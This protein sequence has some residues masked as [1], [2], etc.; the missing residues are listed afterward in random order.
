MNIFILPEDV[1][2]SIILF[3]L[4][5][6]DLLSFGSCSREA[7]S[8]AYRIELW[9]R[10]G[11]LDYLPQRAIDNVLRRLPPRSLRVLDVFRSHGV[12]TKWHVKGSY[13]LQSIASHC[14]G[15]HELYISDLLLGRENFGRALEIFLG[16]CLDLR[17]LSVRLMNPVTIWNAQEIFK[18]AIADGR[19]ANLHTLDIAQVLPCFAICAFLPLLPALRSLSVDLGFFDEPLAAARIIGQCS[20]DRPLLKTLKLVSSRR[21]WEVHDEDLDKV[22]ELSELQEICLANTAMANATLHRICCVL[23]LTSLDIESSEVTHFSADRNS[24][25]TL[26][27]LRI[28]G[29]SVSVVEIRDCQLLQEAHI[30]CRKP[31]NAG[32]GPERT[33]I[34]VENCSQLL[35][36]DIAA[37]EPALHMADLTSLTELK[38]RGDGGGS[39]RLSALTLSS[40]L[41]EACPALQ[42]LCIS[43]LVLSL[44]RLCLN[45]SQLRRLDVWESGR[46]NHTAILELNC[47]RL[48]HINYSGILGVDALDLSRCKELRQV[49]MLAAV[50][51]EWLQSFLAGHSLVQ[52]LTLFGSYLIEPSFD[53]TSLQRLTL[54]MNASPASSLV[55]RCPNLHTL[56]VSCCRAFTDVSMTRMLAILAVTAKLHTLEFTSAS[57]LIYPIIECPPTLQRLDLTSAKQLERLVIRNANRLEEVVLTSCDRLQDVICSKAVGAENRNPIHFTTSRPIPLVGW[58]GSSYSGNQ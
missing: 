44:P 41:E 16:R 58:C 35:S 29:S 57:S 52:D 50:T 42:T 20:K 12:T 33:T 26:K 25:V 14:V 18:K 31:Q 2:C 49:H 45:H 30:E 15:L 36:L 3:K 5:P 17:V 22:F 48:K 54:R 46:L 9:D 56:S 4:S 10:P 21:H 34:V 11:A 51:D 19:L 13:D 28:A 39:V 7:R 40:N 38:F 24:G 55:I 47:P 27:R 37:R 6:T 1:L 53:S 8:L 32:R 43:G 23:S